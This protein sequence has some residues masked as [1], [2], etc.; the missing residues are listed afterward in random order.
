[1]AGNRCPVSLIIGKRQKNTYK[2]FKIEIR[3][4]IIDLKV[5]EKINFTCK[6]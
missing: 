3:Y 1:M 6:S 2:Y 4:V 5:G